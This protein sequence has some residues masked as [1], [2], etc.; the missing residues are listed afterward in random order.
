MVHILAILCVRACMHV[1]ARACDNTIKLSK[2]SRFRTKPYFINIINLKC[3]NCTV[4]FTCFV[5]FKYNLCQY[6][7]YK[8]NLNKT[9]MLRV[10]MIDR[11][12]RN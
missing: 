6:M 12:H 11:I 5:H 8:P 10:L 4:C 3:Q 1:R 2:L 7:Y 9:C